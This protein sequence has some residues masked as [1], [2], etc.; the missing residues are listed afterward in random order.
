MCCMFC[1]I[2]PNATRKSVEIYAKRGYPISMAKNKIGLT[3]PTTKAKTIDAVAEIQ[4]K[5]IETVLIFFPQLS[6][7]ILISF[8][9]T[10]KFNFLY[11]PLTSQLQSVLQVE[12]SSFEC[13]SPP[14]T[15]CG[16]F[17]PLPPRMCQALYRG[18]ASPLPPAALCVA[19]P[20]YLPLLAGLSATFK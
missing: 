10:L 19:L 11:S 6:N 20:S 7:I 18:G 8:S 16:L 3:L 5:T 13:I 9:H 2:S 17:S 15:R 4:N 14:R 12:R 1:V